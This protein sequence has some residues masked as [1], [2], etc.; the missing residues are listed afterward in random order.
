MIRILLMGAVLG[1]FL[2]GTPALANSAPGDATRKVD[3]PLDEA[4]FTTY[5]RD[6]V[7]LL[8]PDAKVT[9]DGPLLLK[10]NGD[11]TIGLARIHDYCQRVPENCADEVNNF[12][13]A[14]TET[15]PTDAYDATMLR[16]AVRPSSYVSAMRARFE[17]NKQTIIARPF[18]GDLDEICVLDRPRTTETVMQQHL[19]KLGLTADAL[20][21]RCEANVAQTESLAAV[22][23]LQDGDVDLL[24]GDYYQSSLV[25]A[26]DAW[27]PI[28]ER[29]GGKLLVVVPDPTAIIYARGDSP[30][31]IARLVEIGKKVIQGAERPLS[32]QIFAWTQDGWKV[33][34]E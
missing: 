29:F 20:F 15:R 8:H 21:A 16:A 28:V 19:D 23:D 31:L 9:I 4:G 1:G 2:L 10:M 25:T 14:M 3:V 5:A 22:K 34:S 27:R 13:S 18:A 7:L 6:R 32:T 24:A 17:A 26:H 11:S 12:I 33:V 30:E